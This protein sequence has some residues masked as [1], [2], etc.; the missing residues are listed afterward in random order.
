MNASKILL[1][2]AL[3]TV[4]GVALA[5]KSGVSGAGTNGSGTYIVS[6]S[7]DTAQLGYGLINVPGNPGLLTRISNLPG[8]V[9]LADGSVVSPPVRTPD[10]TVIRLTVDKDG[11]IV[12]V[13]K[14]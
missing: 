9:T 10:G 14:V 8:A 5:G 6:D 7:E 2:A 1:A 4:S 12:R 3:V 13:E 11:R